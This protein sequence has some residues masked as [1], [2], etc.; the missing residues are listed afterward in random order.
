MGSIKGKEIMSRKNVVIAGGGTGGHIY[1]GIAIARAIKVQHP[2][3]EIHFVGTSAGL[4]NKIIPRE[5][6]PLHHINIGKLNNA[7]GI[8]SKL[9]TLI[10]LP[11]AFVQSVALLME[12][13]PQAVLGVGG[14]A[15]G[16]FVLVASLMGFRTAIW[17]PNAFPGMTN[18]WLSR[19][20]G[21]SFVV[22]EEAAKF[23]KS[24]SISQVGIP[25]RKEVEALA[26][27]E[28]NRPDIGKAE[29]EFHILV[30][31]GSQGARSINI[32]VQEAVLKGG[33]WLKGTKIIHQT[34]AYD[35]ARVSEAYRG[36]GDVEAHEY[37]Y[38]MEKS[39]EWADLIICRAGA[40]TVAEVAACGKPAIFVPLPWAADD[41]QRKNA[42][43]LF[44]QNAAAMILQKD[45]TSE[46]LI[47]KIEEL[48]NNSQ[49]REEMRKNLTKFY[50]P[51][52][53]EKMAELLL[54]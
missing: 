51:Q 50:K 11:R 21:K 47:Q 10:G 14:Y 49:L 44:R 7:S 29:Q 38:Q 41:H 17:E 45:L 28:T 37:L 2:D 22:F 18:R 54:G 4:E 8:L 30:F 24:E 20:A 3:Y 6:F 13:K 27:K 16:P 34:G 42:E 46:S 52:A 9:K 31:G 15:S 5:G 53:A 35:F 26:K 1:P 23:L 12:L 43:S 19:V 39:Y 36:Q 32:A 33:E 48:K 40:S 25:L